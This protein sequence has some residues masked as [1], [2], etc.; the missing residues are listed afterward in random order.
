[1][2]VFVVFVVEISIYHRHQILSAGIIL[3]YNIAF[4]LNDFGDFFLKKCTFCF[5]A[6]LSKIHYLTNLL[7]VEQ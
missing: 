7:T 4:Y 6:I 5:S 3:A 1:L 2:F